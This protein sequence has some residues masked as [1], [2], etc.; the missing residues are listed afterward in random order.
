[1]AVAGTLQKGVIT[2]SVDKVINWARTSV[3]ECDLA[4]RLMYHAIH[5]KVLPKHVEP[6]LV[7]LRDEQIVGSTPEEIAQLA[8]EIRD[9][10]YR[11][12]AAAGEVHLVSSKL[13]LHDAD[14]FVVMQQLSQAG[15]DGGLP[16]NLDPGHAF[17]LGYEMCKALTALTLGKT[18]RQDESLDW[19]LATRP[20]QR[21]Y[22][23]SQ[24]LKRSGRKR[25]GRSDTP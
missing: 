24:G 15:P 20:E 6:R 25:P 12:F 14:P 7:M 17:Y 9:H 22:L 21:H 11:V 3:R 18:Y 16:K 10:N 13:H 1:M 2:T 23:K 19:G 4:R 5:G 8:R